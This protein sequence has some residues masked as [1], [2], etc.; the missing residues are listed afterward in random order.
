MS[1]FNNHDIVDDNDTS[2]RS[3][4]LDVSDNE[5]ETMKIHPTSSSSSSCKRPPLIPTTCF[6]SELRPGS[7][8]NNEPASKR[9]CNTFYSIFVPRPTS[10]TTTTSTITNKNK[11]K[12][13]RKIH[14]IDDKGNNTNNMKKL[15]VKNGTLKEPPVPTK[16]AATS[17][18]TRLTPKSTIKKKKRSTTTTASKK[19]A[20]KDE[21]NGVASKKDDANPS[22]L[23]G[24]VWSYRQD[25]LRKTENMNIPNMLAETFCKDGIHDVEATYQYFV[26]E[27]TNW[28]TKQVSSWKRYFYMLHYDPKQK[29]MTCYDYIK[30]AHQ[31]W[32]DD[33]IEGLSYSTTKGIMDKLGFSTSNGGWNLHHLQLKSMGGS[34]N[35][36]NLKPLE[37][38][39]HQGC[40]L[41]LPLT[42]RNHE[43]S[44]PIKWIDVS[45]IAKL[46]NADEV[47]LADM[48]K[49][50]IEAIR[51]TSI[52]MLRN[53]NASRGVGSN[54]TLS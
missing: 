14:P 17:S 41:A 29:F 31:D 28:S 2:K 38:P 36:R 12:D 18:T 7:I 27:H 35:P 52:G 40:H 50:Y 16:E 45:D 25:L 34:D 19:D 26:Q 53:T 1:N 23:E 6:N 51:R 48:N 46:L 13:E 44:I 10:T 30:E 8:K 49:A 32:T 21:D 9:R 11:N 24:S 39:N 37:H 47:V 4:I 54:P 15:P 43:L 42:F 20:K 3:L 5:Y 33:Y 22:I